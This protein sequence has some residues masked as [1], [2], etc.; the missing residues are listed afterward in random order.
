M[1]ESTVDDE[2]VFVTNQQTTELAK[3]CV[4][5]FDLPSPFV[6][7]QLAAIVVLPF[8]VVLS[9]G[10]N[11]LDALPFPSLPQPFGKDV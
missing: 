9:V 11:Q 3:P 2:E 6:A 10:C 4:G 1:E 8:F 7:S 5:A